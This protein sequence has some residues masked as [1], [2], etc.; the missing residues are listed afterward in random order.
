[1][2]FKYYILKGSFVFLVATFL[3]LPGL[4]SNATGKDTM[5]IK[6]DENKTVYSIGSS[7][8][9]KAGKTEDEKDKER[10]WD[11]LKN[12]NIIIDKQNPRGQLQNGQ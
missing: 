8:D 5:E 11:M 6:R 1:M 12:M 3:L 9:K 4:L 2:K 7:Q 10:A